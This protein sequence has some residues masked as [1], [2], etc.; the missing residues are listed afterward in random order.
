M[1]RGIESS[2]IRFY[3]TYCNPTKADSRSQLNIDLH[4]VQGFYIFELTFKLDVAREK[5]VYKRK[6][7]RIMMHASDLGH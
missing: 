3:V 7:G 4:Y 2:K 5:I 1:M 6:P